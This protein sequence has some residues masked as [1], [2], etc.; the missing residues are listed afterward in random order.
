MTEF[1]QQSLS[2]VGITAA[3]VA[4]AAVLQKL[5][6]GLRSSEQSLEPARE[7]QSSPSR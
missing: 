6:E 2:A 7:P 1:D 5:K 4:I 3:L